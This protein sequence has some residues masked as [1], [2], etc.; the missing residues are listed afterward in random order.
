MRS[1]HGIVKNAFI[2][3]FGNNFISLVMAVMIF[4]TVFSI[5]QSGMGM[6]DK[7]VLEI[8]QTSGPASTGLTFIWMPQLF[9]LMPGGRIIAILFF[10]GLTFAGFSSLMSMLELSSR[11][12]IDRGISRKNAVLIIGSLV[13]I[14]GIP[15][16]MSLN[17]LSNQDFVWGLGLML[18]GVFFSIFAIRQGLRKLSDVPALENDWP[19]NA[20]WRI[21]IA[22]FVPVAGISLLGWWFWLSFTEFTPQ[23]WYNPLEGFSPMTI[24]VQWGIVLIIFITFNRGIARIEKP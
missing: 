2:T 23:Q 11:S 12:L 22:W 10:L 15:S 13:Y 14:M 18:S 8:M 19:I 3:G 1:R 9:A 17:I 21:I 7:E 4:G 20:I 5:L 16:A 6:K 24:L